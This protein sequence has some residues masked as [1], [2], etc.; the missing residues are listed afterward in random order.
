[1]PTSP[2]S[3]LTLTQ[4]G[5]SLL[6][7]GLD[8]AGFIPTGQLPGARPLLLQTNHQGDAFVLWSRSG[9]YMAAEDRYWMT[10]LRGRRDP[11]SKEFQAWLSEA[12]M[13]FD[14]SGTGWLTQAGPRIYRIDR[15]LDVKLAYTIGTD[16]MAGT[17]FELCNP[18]RATEAAGGRVLFWGEQRSIE[19]ATLRG[20]LVAFEGKW[21]HRPDFEL[22]REP[23]FSAFGL[24]DS[25][26]A[27]VG[28]TRPKEDAGLY[29]INLTSARAVKLPEPEPLAFA[30]VKEIL[31]S[32][33]DRYV[34]AGNRPFTP[35]SNALW[36]YRAGVWEK[37]K[38]P[39]DRA[40]GPPVSQTRPVRTILPANDGLWMGTSGNG[41]LFVPD[42]SGTPAQ[43]LDWRKGQ[44]LD[45][46]HRMAALNDGSFLLIG[47]WQGTTRARPA[48]LLKG[49]SV[50]PRLLDLWETT[51]NLQRDGKGHLWTYR[52]VTGKR[53]LSEWDGTAWRDYPIPEE[54]QGDLGYPTGIDSRDR[55]WIPYRERRWIAD[56]QRLELTDKAAIFVPVTAEWILFNSLE[57]AFK[58]S[59]Q[60]DAKFRVELPGDNQPDFSSAGE[61]CFWG[62]DWNRRKRFV[63]YFDGTGWR[64][65][66]L[67]AVGFTRPGYPGQPFF[68]GEGELAINISSGGARAGITRLFNGRE[69][70]SRPFVSAGERDPINLKSASRPAME[71]GVPIVNQ[72]VADA[73]GVEWQASNQQLFL[74]QRSISVPQFDLEEVHPFVGSRQVLEVIVDAKGNAV[75][76]TGVPY[77]TS[78]YAVLAPKELLR[79]G[80]LDT[81]EISHG[82]VELQFALTNRSSDSAGNVAAAASPETRSGFISVEMANGRVILRWDGQG[83]L[84][85]AEEVIGPWRDIP[86]AFSPHAVS[87]T[88][89]KAF[90]RIAR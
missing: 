74:S 76:R 32:G 17:R 16:Q 71:A 79:A 7:P 9:W 88:K 41:L 30:R 36:R 44:P 65:W 33:L 68:T 4:V 42:Q 85:A 72:P 66:E 51:G 18:I 80:H 81:V 40:E 83:V 90:Y 35:A 8:T 31:A 52:K 73:S 10:K 62:M 43:V 47:L 39:L 56:E 58:D 15:E 37:I 2:S 54:V 14:S 20:I 50:S 89:P 19:L 77:G 60:G 34:V 11:S 45:G 69:W 61:I 57:E 63:H 67:S 84:Q 78:S 75:L 82:K 29:E 64:R 49:K 12:E 22:S 13:T 59:A 26:R 53:C 86:N 27:W 38:S 1:M 25:Q 6:L 55:L 5:I 48:E 87:I 46:V 3:D 28:T 21:T 70:I 23:G 24:L